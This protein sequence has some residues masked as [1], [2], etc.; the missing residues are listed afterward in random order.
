RQS[1]D[2]RRL[3]AGHDL[4]RLG[5]DH[6]EAEDAVAARLDEHLHEAGRFSE[7]PHAEDVAHRKPGDAERDA[8]LARLAF[9]QP[10]ARQR[11]V[12][13]QA[14]RHEAAVRGAG[15]SSEVVTDGPEVVLRDVRELRTAGTLADRPDAR[16]G[17]LELPVHPDVASRIE[18]D[19][20]KLEADPRGVRGAT[21]RHQDIAAGDRL[22]S[23]AG[24][25][26]Q[27]DGGAA[28]ALDLEHLGAEQDL[29]SLATEDARQ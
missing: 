21:G 19:P 26:A 2:H 9:V 7:R 27:A 28:P 17:R 5:A 12:R 1:A 8:L 18:L 13:E 23:A 11:R 20:G 3:H 25:Y 4:A 29:D 15:G 22:L 24:A 16:R 14:V 10:D 6:R